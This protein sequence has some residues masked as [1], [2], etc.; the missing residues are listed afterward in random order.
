MFDLKINENNKAIIF[1][2][3]NEKID[4]VVYTLNPWDVITDTCIVHTFNRK[5]DWVIYPFNIDNKSKL[6]IKTYE[7]KH[8]F[9]LP[10]TFDCNRNKKIICVGLN[11]TG[12][13]SLAKGMSQM[14]LRQF[15]ENIGHQFLTHSVIHGSYGDII[16]SIENPEY[17]F[18]EDMPFSFPK[19][20]KNIFK[21]F[22]NEKYILT[23]RNSSEEWVNSC[24]NFY[25]NALENKKI[26]N[27]DNKYP[28]KHMYADV[29]NYHVYNWGYP[30]FKMWNL[31]NSGNI[32]TD[33]K[34][35]YEK[36]NEEFI[37]FMEKNNGDYIVINVSKNGELKKL[38]EWIGIETNKHNFEH[39]NKTK[40]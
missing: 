2:L 25:G 29:G 20:Y 31:K 30:M 36:H 10:L 1:Y 4:I 37:D 17:D 32:E 19:V 38:S 5:N 33:L 21:F 27:F 8:E 28:Y 22:P 35:V 15:P 24:I 18:Y 40:I 12:T 39:I 9:I 6:V 34:E 26:N 16:K 11:K 3:G 7:K 14:G 13:T 23:I